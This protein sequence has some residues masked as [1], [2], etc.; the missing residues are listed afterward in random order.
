MTGRRALP[1]EALGID[2]ELYESA[3]ARS[4]VPEEQFE[5]EM[6]ALHQ[7]AAADLHEKCARLAER[8][9]QREAAE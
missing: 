8:G 1:P 2:I 5:R 4:T 9:Q 7:R 3:V 6:A